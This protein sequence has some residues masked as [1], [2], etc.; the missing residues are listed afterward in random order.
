MKATELQRILATLPPG[1]IDVCVKGREREK[2]GRKPI[3]SAS[4]PE[5]WVL[6]GWVQV[7]EARFQQIKGMK[8]VRW[9]TGP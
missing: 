8:R 1:S 5:D 2:Y 6:H 4:V 9:E 3:I 7:N